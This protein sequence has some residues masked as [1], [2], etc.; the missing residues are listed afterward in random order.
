MDNNIDI[1]DELHKGACMGID[2]LNFIFSK[3]KEEKFKKLL[4][5][6]KSEYENLAERINKLYRDYTTKDIHETGTVAKIMTWYGIQKDTMMDTSV[7]NLADL[8]I[9]GTNMGIIEGKKIINH[10][11][12]D[13]KVHKLCTEYIMM[14]EKY[15]DRLKE[16]L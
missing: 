8:L 14:Q 12:M 11:T 6:Q 2:A 5:N 13:K 3:V 10:K 9:R 16:F 15:L 7:S 4:E 1:L